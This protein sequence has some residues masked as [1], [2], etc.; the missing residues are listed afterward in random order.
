MGDYSDLFYT[1]ADGLTL[2]AR[3]YAGPTS[4]APVALL[5]HG[6]TRNSRD[7]AAIAPAIAK[8]HRVIVV[9]Q[10]GRGRSDWDLQIER[11]QPATYVGDMF[12]LLQQQ[13]LSTVATVGT[14]MGGLIA[15]AMNATQPGVFSRVVLNDIGPVIAQRGLDRITRYVGMAS[16][17]DD[18][19]GAVDYARTVNAEAFPHH[20]DADWSAFAERIATERDGKVVLDYD[21]GIS[22]AMKASEA[23]AVPPDMWPLFDALT[24]VPLMLVRGAITDLLDESCVTEMQQRHPS[25]E[26]VTVPD[27]GHAPMLDEPG[28]CEQLVDFLNR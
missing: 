25:M 5:M 28:V 3:D 6:L 9:E 13:G 16:E 12:E 10:R 27:V 15:M 19:S 23:A 18:W 21:P 17:F 7:F 11:Y 24:G 1:V 22:E 20:T 2:Y 26:L 14:S 8:T 4:D